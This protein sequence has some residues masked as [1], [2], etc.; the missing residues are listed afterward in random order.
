MASRKKTRPLKGNGR[1]G[2]D[3]AEF[4]AG[5]LSGSI[6]ATKLIETSVP[7]GT[8]TVRLEQYDDQGNR[9]LPDLVIP[10][11]PKRRLTKLEF[12]DPNG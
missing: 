4:M 8:G 12:D 9:V 5:L 3:Y 2:L 10:G 7:D 1:D 6:T 11:V